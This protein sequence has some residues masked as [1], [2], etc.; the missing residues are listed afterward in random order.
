MSSLIVLTHEFYPVRGGIAVFIEELVRALHDQARSVEV[1]CPDHKKLKEKSFPFRVVGMPV[2]VGQ[3][4]RS[5][6]QLASFLKSHLNRWQGHRMLLPEPGPLRVFMEAD[7][8]GLPLPEAFDVILHGSEIYRFTRSKHWRPL[9]HSLLKRAASIVCVSSFGRE[10]LLEHFSDLSHK[11][12]VINPGLR[13]DLSR[14]EEV[15]PK[16]SK[17]LRVLSV[18]RIVPAKGQHAMIKAIARINQEL[19]QNVE[20]RLVGP[21]G[22]APYGWYLK[23]LARIYDV[24]LVWRGALDGDALA[25]EYEEADVFALTS[26]PLFGRAEAFGL[27]YL[28]AGFF[29]LPC[30]GHKIG[31]VCDAVVDGQTGYLCDVANPQELTDRLVDLLENKA[32]REQMG[33]CARQRVELFTWKNF[34]SKL[35]SEEADPLLQKREA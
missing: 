12:R 3:G 33:E 22:F 23:I 31:G 19:R 4:A 35:Y 24:A 15:S 8:W 17:K 21:V 14:Q 7:R 18:A 32:L 5:Q 27:V 1:W 10:R 28:E 20:Y 2:P 34:A 25:R 30:V 11:T 26:L 9:F 6:K 29:G 13:S 16:G